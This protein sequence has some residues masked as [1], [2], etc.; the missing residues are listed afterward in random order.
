MLVVQWRV[1]AVIIEILSNAAQLFTLNWPERWD[2]EDFEHEIA[3]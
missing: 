2:I 1:S 3:V